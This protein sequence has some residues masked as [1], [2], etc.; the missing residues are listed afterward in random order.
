[1]SL[2]DTMFENLPEEVRQTLQLYVE[3]ITSLYGP[4]LHAVLL[5][6]SA[7]RGD[8]LPG[9]S[10]LNLLVLVAKADVSL[11]QNYT[12]I[13]QRFKKEQIPVPLFLTEDELLGSASLFP[14]EYTDIA[15]FHHVLM[16]HDPFLDLVIDSEHL[17]VQ[18]EQEV[19]G[20]L[21][22]LRQRLVEGAATM[23]AM[24][25]LLPLS[26]TA[27]LACLRALFRE[28]RIPVP[29]TTD[30]MLSDLHS[31]LGIEAAGLQEVW[32]LKRGLISP[33]PAEFPRLFE[34][35]LSMLEA[36][37]A[38]IGQLRVERRLR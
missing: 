21:L 2:T 29:R 18:C 11:L 8:Y 23:E 28:L 22:R 32:N 20:N 14:L 31:V 38:R 15:A 9:R 25:I 3:R 27:L 7:V 30:S 6:G 33:G 35:Y 37:A 26:L 34:R 16:G 13:H 10:N 1:M 17:S 19:R 24:G 5:Y 4:S 36:V 12:K